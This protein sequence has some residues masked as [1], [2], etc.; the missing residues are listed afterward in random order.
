MKTLAI[1]AD[2]CNG[3]HYRHRRTGAG[4]RDRAGPRLR[5]RSRCA[6]SGRGRRLWA[7]LW[8]RMP[9]T[10]TTVPA[11]MLRPMDPTLTMAGIIP[12]IGTTTTTATG[13]TTDS[14]VIQ[15]AR[16]PRFRAFSCAGLHSRCTRLNSNRAGFALGSVAGIFQR[17]RK[18][19]LA[20][21]FEFFLGRLEARDARGDFLSLAR[22][23]F[24]LFG[25]RHPFF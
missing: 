15:E 16:S 22:E 2:G 12:T 1:L 23:A 19:F 9:G 5:S 17:R 13:A 21:A 20:L 25:H 8:L 3:R 6:G 10:A 18:I 24:F 4:T 11:T 7:V 14:L